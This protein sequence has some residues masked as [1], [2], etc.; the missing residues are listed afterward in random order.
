MKIASTLKQLGF[1]EKKAKIYLALLD[2]GGAS[3]IDIAKKAK[4]KRTTVYNILPELIEDGLVSKSNKQKKTIY[5]AEDPHIIKN[6][7]QE[8]TELADSVIPQL[9][10]L[11]NVIPFKPKI[12]FYEGLGGMKK[13]YN[14][15]L[16]SLN[17]GDTILSYTGISGIW[18]YMP[19]GFFNQTVGKR[20]DKKI[21]IKLIMPDSE[22]ARKIQQEA[23][24]YLREVKI[25]KDT[26]Y[27]F[28]GDVE[29]FANKV[30]ILSYKE[31]FLGIIIESKEIANMQR[32]TFDLMWQAAASS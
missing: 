14:D 30:A 18:H 3:V 29:I 11:Y 26:R 24:K 8:K 2:L 13:F 17:P 6:R 21:R 19:K 22:E 20:V 16:D 1:S 28:C 4:L 32:M 31:D 12:T 23:I 15:I 27:D 10:S 25:V 7:L 5:L 9:T